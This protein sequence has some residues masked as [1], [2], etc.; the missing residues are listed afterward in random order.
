MNM[1][2]FGEKINNTFFSGPEGTVPSPSWKKEHFGGESWRLGNTYHTAIGQY[3]FQVTP[4]QIV[5]GLSAIAT[6]GVLRDPSIIKDEQGKIIRSILISQNFFDVVHDG[7]RLGVL[8]GTG[9]ALN[10]PYVDVATKS[11]TAELGT[12]KSK[13]N[14][15]ITGFFPYKNPHYAFTIVL[16]KGSSHN[17]IGAAAAMKEVLDWM[18]VNT[19]EYFK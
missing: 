19:P 17:L 15:W 13:V 4:L 11:G 1:F 2:G 3:G 7:M 18:N 14:S 16:E 12:E 9:K 6:K 8:E 5:R 10:V